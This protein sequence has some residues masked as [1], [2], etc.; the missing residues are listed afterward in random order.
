MPD[1][2]P[3]IRQFAEG[4]A[5]VS[6][7]QRTLWRCDSSCSFVGTARN[8]AVGKSMLKSMLVHRIGDIGLRI[9]RG[10]TMQANVQ[11]MCTLLNWA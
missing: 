8:R 1:R 4:T 6:S 3:L 5:F 11:R 10:R 2:P 7:A 9:V